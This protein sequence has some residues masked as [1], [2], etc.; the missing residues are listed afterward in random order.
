MEIGGIGGDFADV[1]L[2]HADQNV[3]RLDISVNNL[4]FTVQIL[5]TLENL[6]ILDFVYIKTDRITM[7]GN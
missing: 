7:A 2:I 6:E 4:T 3:L 5:Q 1:G